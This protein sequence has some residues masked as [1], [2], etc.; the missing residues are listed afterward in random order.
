MCGI[1]KSGNLTKFWL[2]KSLTF[3]SWKKRSMELLTTSDGESER[4]SFNLL[5]I[6]Y[7][8]SGATK[9]QKNL[10]WPPMPKTNEI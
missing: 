1:K 9:L 10:K 2:K 7:L 3:H 5:K 4:N 8:I 6:N